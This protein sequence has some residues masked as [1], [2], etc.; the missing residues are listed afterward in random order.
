MQKKQLKNS[1]KNTNKIWKILG[2]RK[3]KREYLEERNCQSDLWQESYLVGQIKGMMRNIGQG[4]K[5]IEDDGK[6]EEQEDKE[7]QKQ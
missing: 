3:R 1:R 4:Q 2:N 5:G 7:Q 6:E